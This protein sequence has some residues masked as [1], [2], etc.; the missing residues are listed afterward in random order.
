MQLQIVKKSQ[1]A[2]GRGV[3][4]EIDVAAYASNIVMVSA[5]KR[6]G[7][8]PSASGGFRRGPSRLPSP[9]H[10]LARQSE[11]DNAE[12]GHCPHRHCPHCPHCP[13]A[14][15]VYSLNNTN[16]HSSLSNYTFERKEKLLV[17]PFFQKY[18]ITTL[19]SVKPPSYTVVV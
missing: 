17:S 7:P 19:I 5:H 11:F 13:P 10:S 14:R 6:Y 2:R 15:R 1:H 3:G 18:T 9:P 16:F 12:S 8:T 4:P